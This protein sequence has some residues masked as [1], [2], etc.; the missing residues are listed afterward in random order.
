MDGEDVF[1][2][3]RVPVLD[4]FVDDIDPIPPVPTPAARTAASVGRKKSRHFGGSKRSPA[5]KAR[6]INTGL[7]EA[8][9]GV[10][11]RR[12]QISNPTDDVVTGKVGV[13]LGENEDYREYMEKM[14]LQGLY[15]KNVYG[16]G[17]DMENGNDSEF[18]PGVTRP[19]EASGDPKERAKDRL[20]HVTGSERGDDILKSNMLGGNTKSLWPDK[21]EPKKRKLMAKAAVQQMNDDKSLLSERVRDQVRKYARAIQLLEECDASC[22][23]LKFATL[24]SQYTG[25][26]LECYY[27]KWS[28]QN[29]G[30]IDDQIKRIRQ[31]IRTLN[32]LT[33][34]LDTLK[35]GNPYENMNLH[36]N[37]PDGMPL[38][39]LFRNNWKDQIA[40]DV[41]DLPADRF[42]EDEQDTDDSEKEE[43]EEEEEEEDGDGG[44]GA[45]D[46][47]DR[48]FGRF[49]SQPRVIPIKSE[50]DSP[51]SD[52][53]FAVRP[54]PS[55]PPSTLREARER[56]RAKS[57]TKL[58]E[59]VPSP[60]PRRQIPVSNIPAVHPG[61]IRD[62]PLRSTQRNLNVLHLKR[63]AGA[64]LNSAMENVT[65][66]SEVRRQLEIRRKKN[67][68]GTLTATLRV[69]AESAI[70]MG[71]ARITRAVDRGTGGEE[72]QPIEIVAE[73]VI[74]E[75]T[76]MGILASAIGSIHN[77]KK[78]EYRA[79]SAT[80]IKINVIQTKEK[81]N[82]D[83]LAA[84]LSQFDVAIGHSQATSSLRHHNRKSGGTRYARVGR[85]AWQLDDDM[86]FT[87]DEV[88][89]MWR[90]NF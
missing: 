60:S 29:S 79:I 71:F 21:S 90:A 78:M 86:H 59:F 14:N 68:K 39:S 75:P 85:P 10:K 32:D 41:F 61:Q 54:P 23:F 65:L 8:L 89:E 74:L 55:L 6:E 63:Q 43:E 81:Y 30:C 82:M 22:P 76:G 50:P 26:A 56:P 70:V 24:V 19:V 20:R 69:L 47:A 51:P 33:R 25:E 67:Y 38:N 45:F 7:P 3:A 80:Q 72:K 84:Y 37:V 83:S 4:D 53:H 57:M 66:L 13:L 2:R 88:S 36:V 12:F 64:A 15:G 17:K 49:T 16:N 34:N 46:N 48:S 40:P 28:D 58:R 1:F 42:P 18:F 9:P 35:Y 44:D 52:A 5:K 11:R 31:E 27:V 77:L 62:M 87:E 73:S